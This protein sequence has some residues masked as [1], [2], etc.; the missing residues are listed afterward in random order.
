MTENPRDLTP[1]HRP[2]MGRL[3]ALEDEN[4]EVKQVVAGGRAQPGQGHAAGTSFGEG[5]KAYPASPS[6]KVITP[7]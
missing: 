4:S 7:A 5:S 1:F 6:I 3:M 2:A